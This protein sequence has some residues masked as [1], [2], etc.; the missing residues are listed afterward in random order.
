MIENFPLYWPEG[1][2]RTPA[3]SRMRSAFRRTTGEVRNFLIHEI[4]MLGGLRVVISTNVP[5]R[6]DGLFYASAR[7]P[8]DPGVAVYFERR[9]KPICFACDQYKTVRENLQAVAMTIEALRGIK[10]WGASDMLER[11]FQGFAAL[12]AAG[13]R[14]ILRVGAGVTLAEAEAAFR[15][16][17]QEGHSDHGGE[18]DM[19]T[20]VQARDEARK[21]LS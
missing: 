3:H 10:R 12:P 17:V 15:A 4:G 7:E 14:T 13:W 11:A 8:E 5:T 16:R 2:K 19:H 20:L 21:E 18:A 6:G 1:W 9:G